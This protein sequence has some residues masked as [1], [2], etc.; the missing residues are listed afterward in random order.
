MKHI[1]DYSAQKWRKTRIQ[2]KTNRVQTPQIIQTN[3]IELQKKKQG[4]NKKRNNSSETQ[5]IRQQIPKGC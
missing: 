4:F 1:Y 5:R 2:I 3:A